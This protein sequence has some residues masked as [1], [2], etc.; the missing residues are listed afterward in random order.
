M[1]DRPIIFSAPMV[2]ALLSGRKTQTRRIL[3]VHLP[4]GIDAIFSEG[5]EMW[6]GCSWTGERGTTIPVRYLRGD[7]LYVRESWRCEARYDDLAPRDIPSSAPIYYAA[8][9]DPRDSEPGCAGRYR[10]GRFMPRWASRL[11]LT[12]TEVRVQRLQ[13]ISEADAIAEGVTRCGW[14]EDMA[15]DGRHVWHV[16]EH[17]PGEYTGL[18]NAYPSPVA[19][20]WELWDHIHGPF[21]WDRNEWVCALTF[22]VQRGNIDQLGA[23]A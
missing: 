15:G 12:V 4:D 11:T 9:P 6:E 18:T 13:E 10:H 5:R 1:A 14:A 2:R 3:N 20:F 23:T 16:P 21:A 19:A 7:R 17:E 22:T 8:D